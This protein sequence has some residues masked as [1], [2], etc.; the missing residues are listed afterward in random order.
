MK[1]PT[2]AKDLVPVNEFR[3]NMADYLRQVCESGRPIVI[4]QRGRAAAVLVEPGVLDEIEE[5]AEL[6]RNV[7]R[8]LEDAAANNTVSSEDLFAELEGI[9]ATEEQSRQS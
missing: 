1:R 8:G 6:V 5:A 9:I 3:S 4:T 2:L 7:V